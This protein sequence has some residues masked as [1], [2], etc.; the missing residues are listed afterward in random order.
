[1]EEVVERKDMHEAFRNVARNAGAAGMLGELGA[2]R[3]RVKTLSVPAFKLVGV[4]DADVA[5]FLKQSFASEVKRAAYG[6]GQVTG[7][8]LGMT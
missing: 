3:S 7:T 2:A 4:G 6:V 8:V 1:M 5:A